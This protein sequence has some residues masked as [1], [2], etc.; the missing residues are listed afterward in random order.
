MSDNPIG[1]A[2]ERTRERN[3]LAAAVYDA[4]RATGKLSSHRLLSYRCPRRCLLLDVVNTPNGLILH[5]PRYK[6]SPQV[7]AESSNASGRSKNTEDGDRRWRANTGFVETWGNVPMSCD[8]VRVTLNLDE[9][10][11]DLD[12][13]HA[14]VTL[15][16]SGERSTP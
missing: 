11:A 5:R 15:T 12:A 13:R 6:L 10:Q 8:H 1:A 16:S 9:L 7:N 14:E 3:A 2:H 4:L